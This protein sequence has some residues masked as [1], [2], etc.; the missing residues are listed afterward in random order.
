[1]GIFSPNL[2]KYASSFTS[3]SYIV[4]INSVRIIKNCLVVT[5]LIS[6][7]KLNLTS[8]EETEVPLDVLTQTV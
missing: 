4:S 5:N 6:I 7:N 8:A 2:I 1:M 3:N